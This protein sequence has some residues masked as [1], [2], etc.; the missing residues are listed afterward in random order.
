MPLSLAVCIQPQDAFQVSW[1]VLLR[2]RKHRCFMSDIDPRHDSERR[3]NA[4]RQRGPFIRSGEPSP[5]T[6]PSYEAVSH[7]VRRRIRTP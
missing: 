3:Q 1:Q 5:T 2:Q 6:R 4:G 7:I